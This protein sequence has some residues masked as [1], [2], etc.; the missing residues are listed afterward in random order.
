MRTRCL[1]IALAALAAGAPARAVDYTRV[2]RT[3][4]KEPAYKQAPRYALLLFGPE[5]KLRVWVVLDGRAAYIDRNGD[6]DLTG[7][8]ERFADISDCRDVEIADPDGKTRY[9]IKA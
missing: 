8:T 4:A 7:P 6:G 9:T 1:L 3:T 2:E 5:A